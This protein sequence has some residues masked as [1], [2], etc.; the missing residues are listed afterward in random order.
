M[1]KNIIIVYDN[2]LRLI[3][4]NNKINL[5]LLQ[6]ESKNLIKFFINFK[7]KKIQIKLRN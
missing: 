3:N 2:I 7:K 5:N 6:V 1:I 4:K